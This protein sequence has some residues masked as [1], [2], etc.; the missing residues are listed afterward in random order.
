M[1]IELFTGR[2]KCTGSV[3]GFR[4][5]RFLYAWF[6]ICSREAGLAGSHLTKAG[7]VHHNVAGKVR[8]WS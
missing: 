6:M 7:F 4:F 3:T 1:L 8:P 5:P 2:K